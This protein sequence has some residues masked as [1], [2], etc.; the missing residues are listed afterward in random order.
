M[1]DIR[2]KCIDG[3]EQLG[4]YPTLKHWQITAWFMR[5]NPRYGGLSPRAYLRGKSWAER[6]KVG[7]ETLIEFGVLKP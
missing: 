2:Y 5:R 4:P 1:P 6:M 3:L 7:T